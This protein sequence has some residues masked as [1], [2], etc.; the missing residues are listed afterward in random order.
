MVQHEFLVIRMSGQINLLDH[1]DGLAGVVC[2]DSET[3]VVNQQF[4]FGLNV[5][6]GLHA[7]GQRCKVFL[8]LSH[9]VG[10]VGG[11]TQV[12]HQPRS[13]LRRC[14]VERRLAFLPHVEPLGLARLLRAKLHAVVGVDGG[15]TTNFP[16][17]CFLHSFKFL[18]VWEFRSLDDTKGNHTSQ[19][20]VLSS[21]LVHAKL[22]ILTSVAW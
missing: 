1:R 20:S 13:L 14:A 19:L 5:C 16:R 12:G 2:I 21:Q 4:A 8:H 6:L 17:F 11:G 3:V 15:R 10:A 18:G 9:R 22:T 7:L